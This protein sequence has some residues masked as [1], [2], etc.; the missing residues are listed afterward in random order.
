MYC[1]T[2]LNILVFEVKITQRELNP[3]EVT[4]GVEAN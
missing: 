3:V 2:T 4:V 1:N